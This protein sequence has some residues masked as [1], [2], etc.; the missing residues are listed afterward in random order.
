ME[1]H[2][3][4]TSTNFEKVS[5]ARFRLIAGCLPQDSK[6]FREPW[7]RSTVLC[8]DF[9]DCPNLFPLAPEQI[10]MITEAIRELALSPSIIFRAGKKIMGWKK[11]EKV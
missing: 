9:V 4:C 8:I 7:G 10:E 6:I 1:S 2:L 11:I 3:D 5:L